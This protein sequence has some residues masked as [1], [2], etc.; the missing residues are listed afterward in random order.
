MKV[1]RG[2]NNRLRHIDSFLQYAYV[3]FFSKPE[4]K[5]KDKIFYGYYRYYNDGDLP[6]FLRVAGI[7]TYQK[8]KCEEALEQRLELTI[9][10][11]LDKYNTVENRRAWRQK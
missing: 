4:K 3:H 7:S 1:Q 6:G 11:F 8:K 5:E 9:K 10:K 2:W